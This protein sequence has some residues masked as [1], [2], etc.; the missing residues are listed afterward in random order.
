MDFLDI[1]TIFVVSFM[2]L[3]MGVLMFNY[4]TRPLLPRASCES[5]KLVSVLI[6]AR[7][8]EDNIGNLLVDLT[9][10]DYPETEIL[11]YDDLSEDRTA[12]VVEAFMRQHPKIQLLRGKQLPEG[13]LGK[14]HACHHLAGKARGH[15][16]LFIDADVRLHR[17]AI[18]SAVQYLETHKL[19][20]LSLFPTQI[21]HTVGE[22]SLVPLMDWVLL[23][24]LPLR[25]VEK[26]PFPSLAAANGQFFLHRAAQ[27]HKFRWHQKFKAHRVEDVAIA[28]ALK[29]NKLP[30]ATLLGNHWV[31]CRM[32]K[33][34]Y[35]ALKGFSKNFPFFFGNNQAIRYVFILVSSFGWILPM[36]SWSWYLWIPLLVALLMQHCLLARLT[37]QSCHRAILFTPLR[38]ISLLHLAFYI[39]FTASRRGLEW[40][41]RPLQG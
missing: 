10:Q 40:K 35:E 11:V 39:A 20:A 2:I 7:N 14:N 17:S 4:L 37:C 13:W 1:S 27:Y 25:L 26:S 9:A 19:D 12:H 6:P 22:Q 33:G 38:Q 32:Y 30:M 24:L 18:S 23:T 41:G 16:L 21:M 34:Y 3:R 8:E 15:Y 31:S 29:K 28:R 36:V 5:S